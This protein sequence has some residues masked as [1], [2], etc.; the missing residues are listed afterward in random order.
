MNSRGKKWKKKDGIISEI[1][2]KS[3]KAQRRDSNENLIRGIEEREEN[4]E[5]HE[6][7]TKEDI[8]WIREK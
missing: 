1:R 7:D 6:T 3:Q 5:E 4:I 8:K 2:K